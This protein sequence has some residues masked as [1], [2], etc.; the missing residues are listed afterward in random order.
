MTGPHASR[1][2][3]DVPRGLRWPPVPW[4]VLLVAMAVLAQASALFLLGL[5]AV[6]DAQPSCG[7]P[8]EATEVS[9]ARVVLG[10][11]CLLGLAPWLVAAGAT[12][13]ARWIAIG[14]LASSPALWGL[15]RVWLAP[16]EHLAPWFCF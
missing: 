11:H 13:R 12:R 2:R 1:R 7:E 5:Y 16:Q 6:V 4:P 14:V 8:V 3:P 9:A 15:S 10:L